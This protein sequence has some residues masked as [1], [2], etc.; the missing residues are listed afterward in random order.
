VAILMRTSS[1]VWKGGWGGRQCPQ[2]YFFRALG[3]KRGEAS[4]PSKKKRVKEKGAPRRGPNS[5]RESLAPS[6]SNAM[7]GAKHSRERLCVTR[8]PR[9]SAGGK[10]ATTKGAG[11]RKSSK[12]HRQLYSA[13]TSREDSLR[14]ELSSISG[15]REKGGDA[16]E[17]S[18]AMNT[19]SLVSLKKN[20]KRRGG[21]REKVRNLEKQK[22]SHLSLIAANHPQPGYDSKRDLDDGI[23]C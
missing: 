20:T 18:T 15:R 11:C 4:I 16:R 5:L 21:G 8:R 1:V 19:G 17:I 9:S 7:R 2:K 13:N 3:G 12:N 14:G 6:F 23:L 22:R 10:N